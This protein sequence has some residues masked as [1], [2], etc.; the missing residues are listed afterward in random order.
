[1]AGKFQNGR[2]L[3]PRGSTAGLFSVTRRASG[4][5]WNPDRR[6]PHL[7]GMKKVQPG[8]FF[9]GS[10]GRRPADRADRR[11]IPARCCA[12]G[13]ADGP[14][15]LADACALLSPQNRPSIAAPHRRTWRSQQAAPPPHRRTAAAPPHRRR[16]AAA[17]EAVDAKKGGR[18]VSSPPPLGVSGFTSA[19]GVPYCYRVTYPRRRT[20]APL[21]KP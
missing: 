8:K 18:P 9:G 2:P 3:P 14:G 11:A 1:M 19:P 16:T 21:A 4:G 5:F 17:G 7:A 6:P 12:I 20:A 13:G 10:P 15:Q